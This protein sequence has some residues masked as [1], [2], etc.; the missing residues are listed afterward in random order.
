[1]RGILHMRLHNWL[2]AGAAGRQA[3]ARAVILIGYF[4]LEACRVEE[5]DKPFGSKVLTMSPL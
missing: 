1:M 5:V 3:Q 4:D 2:S